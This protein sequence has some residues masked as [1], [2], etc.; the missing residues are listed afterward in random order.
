MVVHVATANNSTTSYD[1]RSYLDVA[2]VRLELDREV[3]SFR[4]WLHQRN[5]EG[6]VNA[7]WDY[8]GDNQI[9]FDHVTIHAVE[10]ESGEL[11]TKSS[12]DPC[13]GSATTLAGH[14][15]RN[16]RSSAYLVDTDPTDAFTTQLY[17]D[18]FQVV[19]DSH[20][21]L[22]AT[23][24]SR[25]FAQWLNFWR[26]LSVEGD[27]GSAAWWQVAFPKT[28][29]QWGDIAGSP[30]F[31]A[32]QHNLKDAQG[33]VIRYCTYLFRHPSYR[34]ISHRFEAG[35]REKVEGVL[36]VLGTIGV[37]DNGEIATAPN[38]R[39]LVPTLGS[40]L[41]IPSEL[42]SQRMSNRFFL[43]SA[44]TRVDSARR[45]IT[46]D[47][48]NT[49]PELTDYDTLAAGASCQ[50]APEKVNLGTLT[51]GVQEHC[52]PDTCR[53][54]AEIPFTTNGD[55][56]AYCRD[57]YCL[58]AGIIE[59]PYPSELES[60]VLNGDLILFQNPGS[61]PLLQ[62]NPYQVLT[63]QRG[64][65]FDLEQDQTLQVPIQLLLRGN[66]APSGL[67]F[68][69]SQTANQDYSAS[70][71]KT[72]RVDLASRSKSPNAVTVPHTR[73][74][75]FQRVKSGEELV[76]IPSAIRTGLN[77]V[78]TLP[79]RPLSAG[80]G[81]IWI[82]VPTDSPWDEIEANRD[83]YFLRGGLGHYLNIRVL[84]DDRQYDHV[85]DEE[86]TWAFMYREV[87]SYYS[88]LY[89]G[90][91]RYVNF[92]DEAEMRSFAGLI[93]AFTAEGL[94][95]TTLYMP[96]TRELSAGKRRLIQRWADQQK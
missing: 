67:T 43:G 50:T 17:S 76:Q 8:Y 52:A 7:F 66:P 74:R 55:D 93:K 9:G 88:L 34:E 57:R 90:M 80:L 81:K 30:G 64:L 37:W 44:L 16:G 36:L 70:R 51:L 89:P 62:E 20:L 84:P 25:G 14:P 94:R 10:L 45:T 6:Y 35:Q 31:N 3:E 83:R 78:A 82:N 95:D 40:A 32:L 65:Y 87:F 63:D 53:R 54:I 5:P 61:P 12:Q 73:F 23:G 22:Q 15:Y 38:A 2:A 58:T 4:E 1:G 69:V 42:R 59:I 71:V 85:K 77:G 91:N 33:L 19:G 26:N 29:L 92:D 72:T 56:P 28:G 46:I 48:V 60:L 41:P 68:I 21:M 11:L 86:L 27:E 39:L 79:I 18:T 75:A 24:A 49:I 96:V 13:I 47:L